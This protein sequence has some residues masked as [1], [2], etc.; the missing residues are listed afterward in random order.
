MPIKKVSVGDKHVDITNQFLQVMEMNFPINTMQVVS[1][2]GEDKYRVL[3]VDM[4]KEVKVN[5]KT[6][7]CMALPN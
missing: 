5:G 7:Y 2:D 3:V 6:A 1:V 4:E